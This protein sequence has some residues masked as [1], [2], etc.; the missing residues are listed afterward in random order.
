MSFGLSAGA[1]AGIGAI[2]GGL[3]AASATKGAANAQAGA[4]NNASAL[5]QQ[6]YQQSRADQ[7]SQLAQQRTDTA[8]YREAGYGALSQL[9]GGLQ[10]GGDF[11][12]NFTMADYQADP[13]YG[14]RISQGE[15]AI[16]RSAGAAGSR[17]S[18]ATLKAL[19][20][21][22]SNLASQEYG[23]AYNRFN[24]DIGNR[25]NRLSSLAG[26]GQT[27]VSQIGA[28][29]QNTANNIGAAGQTAATNSGNALQNA[30]AARA[31]GYVGVG[32]AINGTIGNLAN[33]YQLSSLM[34][35][36][37]NGGSGYVGGND[38]YANNDYLTS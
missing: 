27:A 36:G 23:N 38:Y 37:G 3:I 28:A 8:P 6:Q 13:G 4:A 29:G 25:F 14:F 1:I 31:S 5:Q 34:G 24:T 15:N 12:R 26:T 7:L 16:N 33:N 17:Y 18:G 2:G 35:G 22:N 20:R 11:N 32:N 19:Q 9:T 10:P 30:A 21:F